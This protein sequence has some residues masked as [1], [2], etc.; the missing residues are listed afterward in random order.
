MTIAAA[1]AMNAAEE[2]APR[3][4][5][6]N[7]GHSMP[8]L[9]LGTWALNGAAC[10][11]AVYAA[12][13]A[14][15]RLIDTAKYYGNEREVGRALARAVAEG[16]VRREEVFITTK[17][18]PW[19]DTPDADID[20]S[21]AKLGVDWIDLCLLH[22]RGASDDAVYGAMVRAAK[23]GKIRSIGISNFYTPGA[24][25][26][27]IKK[28]EIPPAVVQNENHIFYQNGALSDWCRARG[29]FVESWYPFGGRGHVA[30]HLKHPVVLAIAKACG[31]TAAQVILRWH[32]QAGY[33][34]VPGSGDPAHI[35][36]NF[37]I[38]DFALDEA[39]M[40]R[41]AALDTGRRYENW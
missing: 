32:I 34:A 5:K 27:F 14:G 2:S 16:L 39:E 22:Q 4:V 30:D 19:S 8:T 9:G 12:L 17:L 29:I 41:L 37:A 28:F 25:E 13:K 36:E 38:W 20:D 21:L 23:A 7:S 33:L 15:Y 6:L 1:N 40:R 24:V 35:A 11:N 18:L 26:R 10:E 31:K 3:A